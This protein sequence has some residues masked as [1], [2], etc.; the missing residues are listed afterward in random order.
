MKED[1]STRTFLRA[2]QEAINPHQIN[3]IGKTSSPQEQA[4]TPIAIE[5]AHKE[6]S[7]SRR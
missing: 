6:K 3:E 5:K 1:P 4:G 2:C 7:L